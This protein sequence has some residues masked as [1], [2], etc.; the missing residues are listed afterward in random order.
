MRFLAEL[1]KARR[2]FDLPVAVMIAL[3]VLLWSSQSGI[4][5]EDELAS[6]YSTFYYAMPIMN[7]VI[8]PTGMAVLASRIWDCE[9]KGD[10][11]K[12]LFTLQSRESLYRCKSLLGLLEN[13]LVCTIECGSLLVMGTIQGFTEPF[14]LP[15]FSW[16]AICTFSVNSMLLLAGLWLSIHFNNQT[17]VL[18]AG[19]IGSFTALFTAYMPKIVCF[20]VPW[21][22]YI[23]L[24]S[25]QMLWDSETRIGWYEPVPFRFWLLGITILLAAAFFLLGWRSLMKK[26]V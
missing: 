12:L 7:T 3:C 11:C 24:G 19:I 15:Q 6:G 17:G 25:T 10:C 16:L 13:L 2:R 5:T 9:T 14:S 18:S 26:E 20:F 21:A 1:K 23:P 8:M 22:Y 4:N